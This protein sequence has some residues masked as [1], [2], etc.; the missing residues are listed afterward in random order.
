[1]HQSVLP[2]VSDRLNMITEL[3]CIRFNF[4]QLSILN[5]EEVTFMLHFLCMI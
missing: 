4:M 1:M 2:A 3:L 5:S